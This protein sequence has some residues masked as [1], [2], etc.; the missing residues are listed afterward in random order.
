MFMVLVRQQLNSKPIIM[1]TFAWKTETLD[2]R[3][4]AVSGMPEMCAIPQLVSVFVFT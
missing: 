1:M 4:M 2:L 3:K